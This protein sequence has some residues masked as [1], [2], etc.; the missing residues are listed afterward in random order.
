VVHT[1][2]WGPTPVTSTNENKYYV[3][4][5]DQ[6]SRFSWLYCCPCKSDIPKIFT[7]FKATVEN[8]LSCKIKTIQC[9]GGT[10]FSP[11][12]TQFLPE[13]NGLAERKHGH[14]VELSPAAMNHTSIPLDY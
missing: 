12:R 6:Y 3:H 2:I 4:F 11:I 8:L 13:H 10:E 7:L 9:D 5:I 1:D 14:I